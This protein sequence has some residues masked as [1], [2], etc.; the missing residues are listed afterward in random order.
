[1]GGELCMIRGRDINTILKHC[2]GAL[3]MQTFT[4][5]ESLE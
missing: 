3:D 1:M 4:E 5:T 2:K